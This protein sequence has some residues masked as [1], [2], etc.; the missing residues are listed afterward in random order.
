MR[1]T[2]IDLRIDKL[3][4]AQHGAFS[5]QQAFELGASERFVT[6]RLTQN[7]WVRPVHAVY[8]L[9]RS[10]GTWLRQCMIA[11][12]SVEGSAI[13]GRTAA[14]LHG[15]TGF[16]QGPIELLVP[17]NASCRHPWAALHRY[18]GAQLTHVDG[19]A[20]TTVAQT[21]FDVA[22][23]VWPWP[24]ERAL[25]DALLEKRITVGELDERLRF[26]EGSRRPG[27]PRIRPLILER[28]EE[29]WIP[30]ES[31]LE[32]LLLD[33]LE[34]LPSRP[35]IL[36]QAAMP[37]LAQQSG[38][39]DVLLPDHRLVVEADGRRWHTRAAD[40]DRDRWRDNQAAAND[41]R[42][43]RFTWVHLRDLADDVV[44]VVERAI[45]RSAVA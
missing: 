11:E 4:R 22:P 33:V 20:V 6:R 1:Y 14:A 25:D 45:G 23:V 29:T 26:Y 5:R 9:A 44:A 16:R 8:A 2:E 13:A 38:R 37:W 43:M 35:R 12:L 39:V 34:R 7:E 19:I 28:R 10:A 18:S 15:L 40:F 21:M 42:V 31:E 3:A 36:R 30:P 17:V 24:L 32:A 41:H 27:L